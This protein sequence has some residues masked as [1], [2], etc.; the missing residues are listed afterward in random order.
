MAKREQKSVI[1]IVGMSAAVLCAICAAFYFTFHVL[2]LIRV[3]PTGSMVPTIQEKDITIANGQ[4]YKR[5]G[6]SRFDVVIIKR[7]GDSEELVKRV[8]GMPGDAI[9]FDAGRIY[10][11]GE[12]LEE[13]FIDDSVITSSDNSYVVPK[14]C[15]FVLGDNRSNSFDSIDWEDPYVKDSEIKGQVYC[16]IGVSGG[17]HLHLF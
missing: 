3:V 13:P 15:Y 8:I 7:K 14:G 4:S 17:P 5:K 1:R 9:T 10:V 6:V 11:N 16:S 2:F 12:L